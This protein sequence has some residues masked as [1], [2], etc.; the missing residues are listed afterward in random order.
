P[1]LVPQ[2]FGSLATEEN[3]VIALKVFVASW[4]FT[5]ANAT[6]AQKTAQQISRTGSFELPCAA[7]AAF[8]LFSPEGERSWAKG[9]TPKPVFPERIEFARDTVFRGGKAG[10]AAVWTIIDADWKAFRAEYVRV[11]PD[12]HAAHIVVKIESLPPG[13]SKV[14]V[15]YTVTAFG[16][17][18]ASL[19]AAF[20]EE[21]YS[22]KMRDW[23][24][25]IACIWSSGVKRNR[26]CN[27]SCSPSS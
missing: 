22:S 20:S 8:P 12:S 3:P 17:H 25:Q 7:D 24:R 23:Q 19:L 16:E 21:A 26:P 14:V 15:S 9:W 4:L 6:F 11:S 1:S 10:E 13:R 27:L 18:P 2:M 5:L